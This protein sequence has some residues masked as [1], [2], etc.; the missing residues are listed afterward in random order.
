MLTNVVVCELAIGKRSSSADCFL[1]MIAYGPHQEW[2][3]LP[4]GRSIDKVPTFATRLA[5]FAIGGISEEPPTSREPRN[6]AADV[7]SAGPQST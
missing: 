5:D 1:G 4:N 7:D 2:T 6:R 3:R